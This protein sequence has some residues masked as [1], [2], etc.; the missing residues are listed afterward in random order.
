[1]KFD[2]NIIQLLVLWMFWHQENSCNC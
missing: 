1:M 2:L